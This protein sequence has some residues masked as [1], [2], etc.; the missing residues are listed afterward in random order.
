MTSRG[1]DEA[2]PLFWRWYILSPH[3]IF[4]HSLAQCSHPFPHL[5]TESP[6]PIPESDFVVVC[7]RRKHRFQGRIP[8]ERESRGSSPQCGRRAVR[9]H[10]DRRARGEKSGA[11]GQSSGDEGDYPKRSEAKEGLT[12]QQG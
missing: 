11:G 7:G 8:A 9:G 2:G 6:A 12:K 5:E 3:G 10:V 1:T 4:S